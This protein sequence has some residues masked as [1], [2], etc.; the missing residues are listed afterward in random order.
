M[1]QRLYNRFGRALK[2][3]D[4]PWCA[5]EEKDGSEQKRRESLW[6]RLSGTGRTGALVEQFTQEMTMLAEGICEE[7]ARLRQSIKLLDEKAEKDHTAAQQ[8]WEALRQELCALTSRLEDELTVLSQRLTVLEHQRR[9]SNVVRFFAT[10]GRARKALGLA[11]AA[12]VLSA[13][14]RLL[15]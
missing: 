6:E 3:S 11:V 9:K 1:E 5:M 7:Q 13:L 15:R 10:A 4:A 12:M 2:G 14:M 8:Q